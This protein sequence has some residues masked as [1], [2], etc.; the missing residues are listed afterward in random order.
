M[1]GGHDGNQVGQYTRQI[2]RNHNGYNANGLIVVPGIAPLIANQNA[3]QNG[4]GNVVAARAEGDIDEIEDVNANCVL[5]ANLWQAL[6]SGIQIGKAPVYD[7]DGTSEVPNSYN[8]YDSEIFNIFNQEEQYTKLLEPISEPHQF[9]QND[10]NVIPDTSSV[11][12]S[13]GTVGQNPATAEEIR[14]HFE[15][16]YNNLA[17]EVERVNMVNRKMRE[18]ND[19]LTT[20]LARYKSYLNPHY[21]KQAQQKQ[22]S[23][24]NVRVLLEKHDHRVVYDSEETLQLAQESRLKMKQLNKE[25][26]PTNYAKINKLSEVFVSQK[27]KSREEIFKDDIVPIVN[28]V[29]ARVQNFE[30]HFVK[31]VAKFVRDFKS[32]AKEAYDSLDK[33]KVLEIK[34]ER[35]LRAVVSEDIMSIVQNNFVVDKSDLQTKLDRTK[36]KLEYYIIKKGKEYASL[37][38]D[39]TKPITVSQPSVIHQKTMNSNSTGSSSTGVDNTAKTRRPQPRSNTMYDRVQSASKSSGLKNKQVE[40]EEH[41]RNLLLSKNKRHIS[42]ECNNIKLAIRND[43]SEVVCGICKQCLITTNHDVY[44]LTYVNYMNFHNTKQSANISNIKKQKPNVKKPKKVGSN[45]RL[46][47]PTPSESSIYRRND[48]IAAILGYGDLQWGNILI[49]RV[50]FIEGLGHNL[51]SVGQFYDSDLEFA[52]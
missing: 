47:S 32:L 51:F 36:D 12:Q 42:S 44:V 4:N 16:L 14:D 41:R 52:F 28:Q 40:E 30:N 45:E 18:T 15:S 11:E 48:H 39:W 46:T 25:I 29:D 13:G 50:Y 9:Q 38:N 17:T 6:T 21:L 19:D 43:K 33:K 20:E 10:N 22:Q 31:E 7:S 1:I 35:L 26:K 24:Y 37:W 34:N 23:L 2:A 3:N 27:A 5:M 49:T 8:C